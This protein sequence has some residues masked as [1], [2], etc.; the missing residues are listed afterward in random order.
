MMT[1]EDWWLV[2][3]IAWSVAL[4]CVLLIFFLRPAHAHDPYGS[5]YNWAGINC[6]TGHDCQQAADPQDFTPIARGYLIRST[7]EIVPLPETGFSPDNHWHV[8][9]KDSGRGAVRCLLVPN[10]G[11]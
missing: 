7:G 3:L 2:A 5:I 4:A 10:G 1:R 8:C 6:C 9:R 11:S